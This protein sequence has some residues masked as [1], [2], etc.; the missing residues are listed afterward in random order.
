M[1]LLEK[2]FDSQKS[3]F[4]KGGKLQKLYP[5]YEAAD[6]FLFT[7]AS[8]T[9]NNSHVR[10][11][12]DLKRTMIM[13]GVALI[14]AVFMACY[15]T[16]YQAN[17]ALGAQTPEGWRASAMLALGLGFDAQSFLSNF[18]YGLLFFLPVYIVTMAVGGLWEAL[19]ASVRGH[20]INEGFVVTGLLFPLTLPPTIPLWQVAVGISFG[21]VIGKEIFGGTGR[22]V[23]NP[24]LMSRAFLFFAYHAQISGDAV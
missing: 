13:V 1:K 2:F 12:I 19:F 14:P 4:E 11:A 8:V 3:L 10:D 23:F 6:T 9:K 7:P 17:L 16:G 18:V 22:N 15:N 21:V 20:E 24:A 5:L